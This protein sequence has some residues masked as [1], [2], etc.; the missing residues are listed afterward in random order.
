MYSQSSSAAAS[1]Q[2][3]NPFGDDWEQNDDVDESHGV[4]VK[5][6]YDHAG[7]EEDELSFRAG[8]IL[9]YSSQYICTMVR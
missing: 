8:Q 3:Q 2:V 7:Q 1:G 6:L 5:A 4:L 9:L